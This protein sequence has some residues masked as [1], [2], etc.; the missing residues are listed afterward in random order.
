[1]SY[2]A[3]GI[4]FILGVSVGLTP[5]VYVMWAITSVQVLL[6]FMILERQV[7]R[8]SPWS[9]LMFYGGS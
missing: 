7:F 1:M 6:T 9:L 5:Y 8:R 2:R 4:Y 3:Q